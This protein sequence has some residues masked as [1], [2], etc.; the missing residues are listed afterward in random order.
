MAGDMAEGDGEGS[1]SSEADTDGEMSK[2]N[3]ARD[4]D[5]SQ[6]AVRPKSPAGG[7]PAERRITRP[8]PTASTR[9]WPRPTCAYAGRID[10][11]CA[12]ISTVS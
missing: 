5:A 7:H 10:P 11:A 1:E 3:R 6:R 4:G 8:S 9:K 2:A 12:P